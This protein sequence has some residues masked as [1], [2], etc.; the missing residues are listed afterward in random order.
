MKYILFLAML[1][2]NSSPLF[3]ET[4]SKQVSSKSSTSTSSSTSSST[5][6]TS[7]ASQNFDDGKK[8][9]YEY[10]K[11]EYFDF[12]ALSVKG[13]LLSPGDLSTKTNRRVKFQ[14]KKYIRKNFDDFIADDLLEVY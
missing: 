13:E 12:E 9:I 4:K 5:S 14:L 7:A 2:L 10:K 11:D 6:R 8:V 3:S 1:F